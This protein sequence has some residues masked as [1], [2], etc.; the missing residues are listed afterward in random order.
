MQSIASIP[1]G[2]HRW[3]EWIVFYPGRILILLTVLTAL[4]GIHIPFLTFS[5]S[6]RHLIVDDL[7]ERHRYDQFKAL[8]GNDE[9]IQVVVKGQYM[10]D[11]SAFAT[12]ERLSDRLEKIPGVLRVISLP[13]VKAAVD[14]QDQWTL[15]RF[16]TLVTPVDLFQRYLVSTDKRVAGITLLLDDG[17]DHEQMTRSVADVLHRSVGTSAAYQIGMPT[18]CTALAGYARHDI[19][20]LPLC[21]VAIIAVL[22]LLV[23]NRIVAVAL[24]LAC[25]A[26][27]VIWT[28][29]AMAWIG[30]PLN[31]LT[32]VV[33]I[34]Q[35]AVGTAY[36]LYI[37]CEFQRR[38]CGDEDCGKA[39]LNTYSRTTLA[40]L[41]AVGT[42]IAG[43]A[44]LVVTPIEAVRQ[45]SAFA[46]MGVAAMLVAV[47]TVLPCLLVFASPLIGSQRPD[48]VGRL[49]SAQRVGR[50]V[51]WIIA[52]RRPVFIAL[53][54][55]AL[56][57]LA[58]IARIRVE[59]NPLAYFRD[60]TV[61][62]RQFHDIYRHL[63]GCFPLHV[64]VRAPDEDA[65]R[66]RQFLDVISDHQR[67]LETLPGVDKT[68]ALTDYL[69][70]VNYVSNRFDPDSYALPAADYEI[71]MLMNQFK[72]ILGRVS[73]RDMSILNSAWPT[74]P[75]CHDCQRPADSWIPSAAFATIAPCI[76]RA[77]RPARSPASVWSCPWAAATWCGG[78]C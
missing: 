43:L 51:R 75:C 1:I 28:L 55:F 62:S 23:F 30:V 77:G 14:P 5:G 72:S 34:F 52:W 36:C 53:A 50:L 65:F 31:M 64:E 59:T 46:C 40:T 78:R 68:M 20:T 4:A 11:A 26:V 66:S 70:L 7:P 13:R 57:A 48:A 37:Y 76:N 74:S 21:T 3:F 12:L 47:M 35:I 67:F 60:K 38:L 58:G 41:T 42:T 49:F 56:V 33:P 32:V 73:F 15:A 29:G 69:M 27:A 39:L 61:I 9:M 2:L 44:S 16:A 17:V 25:V 6:V 22:L 18:V 19:V 71:R 10:F 54:C 45:F 63:S 8:F 24:P